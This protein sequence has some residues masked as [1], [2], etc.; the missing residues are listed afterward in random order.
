LFYAPNAAQAS[1][2]A[3]LVIIMTAIFAGIPGTVQI[4]QD[5]E[6]GPPY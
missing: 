4:L 6:Y 5:A 3:E 2:I 1:A